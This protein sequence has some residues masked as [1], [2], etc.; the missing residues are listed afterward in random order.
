MC[1]AFCRKFLDNF[2]LFRYIFQFV[3]YIDWF[4][5]KFHFPTELWYFLHLF[6]Q[7]FKRFAFKFH[8]KTRIKKKICCRKKRTKSDWIWFSLLSHRINDESQKWESD[9]TAKNRKL[10]II[11]VNK[12]ILNR[13]ENLLIKLKLFK[14]T[15]KTS[16]K[17][18]K[19]VKVY[20]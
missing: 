3:Q 17:I 9:L 5:Q 20:S 2:F 11:K 12:K 1:G 16:R 19:F 18:L 10:P 8:I 7:N 15:I 13:R 4:P 6:T 14:R